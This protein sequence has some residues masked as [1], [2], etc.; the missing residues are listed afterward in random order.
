MKAST[1]I[2]RYAGFALVAMLANL[3]AQRLVLGLQG[4]WLLPAMVA[5]T[6]SGLVVK[7]LL[8]KRW[9]FYDDLRPAREEGRRFTLYTATGIGTTLI[10]WG[11][12]TAFW[13]I[14]QTQPMREIGALIGLSIGYVTKY[15]LDRRFVFGKAAG[16]G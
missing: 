9:I 10:F 3:G 11:S 16:R 5:G 1:L 6:G 14:W 7:Y 8:D 13:L 12:E 4:G 2:L 15:R